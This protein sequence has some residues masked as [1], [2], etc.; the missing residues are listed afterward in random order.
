MHLYDGLGSLAVFADGDKINHERMFM[1]DRASGVNWFVG[2][3]CNGCPCGVF[4]ESTTVV[5]G[6]THLLVYRYDFIG[7]NVDVRLFIDPSLTN[8]PPNATA[9]V[10]LVNLCGFDFDWVEIG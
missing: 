10:T 8:A 3:T 1:G 6:T 2:G 5:T 4:S 9:A 7:T